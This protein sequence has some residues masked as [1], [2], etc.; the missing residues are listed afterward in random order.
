MIFIIDS[1]IGGLSIY[2]KV[3]KIIPNESYI[4]FLDN[5]GFPYGEKKEKFLLKRIKKISQKINTLYKIR[6]VIL[7]C[8]TISTLA[9]FKIQNYFF[10]PTV[11]TTPDFQKAFKLSKNRIIGLLSTKVTNSSRYVKNK[12]R[13]YSGIFKFLVLDANNMTVLSEKKFIGKKVCKKSIF[14]ILKPI[15]GKK[16]L[17]TIILGCTHFYIL[18][19]EIL[20]FFSKKIYL[21][22]SVES[23]I[24]KIP[25]YFIGSKNSQKRTINNYL[26]YS[27]SINNFKI[28]KKNLEQY[29]FFRIKK[30][31]I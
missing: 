23:T 31:E 9:Y 24:K 30:I 15:L 18:K 13:K 8:N 17:D 2:K 19:K 3:R 5:Q 4:Y 26:L 21:V 1:G 28:F 7:A 25:S 27:K 6:L 22:D 20:S 10:C 14:N 16:N 12:I 11:R 29:N